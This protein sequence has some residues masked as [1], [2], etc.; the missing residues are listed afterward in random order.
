MI[1]LGLGVTQSA[2]PGAWWLPGAVAQA[3]FTRYRFMSMGQGVAA[4][5]LFTD[6][7]ATI[8]Y[9]DRQDATLQLFQ[10]NIPRI[11]GRGSLVE[12]DDTNSIWPSNDFGNPRW[13][14]F[15][16][17]TG[18]VPIVTPNYAIAP[19]GTMTASRLQCGLG[20]GT[21]LSDQSRLGTSASGLPNPHKTATGAWLKSNTSY[22]Q[23][24]YVDT[25]DGAAFVSAVITSEW[26]QVELLNSATAATTDRLLIGGRGGIIPAV[27]DILDI[28]VWEGQFEQSDR[29][30]SNIHTSTG[31][32]TR[33]ADNTIMVQSGGLPFPGYNPNAFTI[34]VEWSD[35]PDISGVS[36]YLFS[37]D[38]GTSANRVDFYKH[39]LGGFLFG[40]ASN[41]VWANGPTRG[42]ALLAGTH[43]AVVRHDSVTGLFS[44]S[45]DGD[46]VTTAAVP[47]PSGL[48]RCS[49]ARAGFGGHLNG[50]IRNWAYIPDAVSDA[51][52]Q[53]LKFA[54]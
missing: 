1:G 51:D 29:L 54:A 45:L 10:P 49:L 17:G 13:S 53:T 52:M 11:T 32:A 38:D 15:A 36:Q 14:K 50:Y 9:A 24:V 30:S 12:D 40:A 34:V 19:D 39:S 21:A 3:G 6:T 16:G 7:R 8:G 25:A 5:Q 4:A 31:P 20:G 26:S 33:A 23:N 41:G 37:I 2:N 42:S 46:A 28:L 48:S 44:L 22:D 47:M 43:R 27:T 35:A 18:T